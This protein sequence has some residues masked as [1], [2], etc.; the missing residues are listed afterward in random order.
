VD[1]GH[2]HK[3]VNVAGR[4]RC[5]GGLA[6]LASSPDEG[7]AMASVKGMVQT[8]KTTTSTVEKITVHG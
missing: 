2:G 6:G 4:G 8:A 5:R 7:V 3:H 1:G